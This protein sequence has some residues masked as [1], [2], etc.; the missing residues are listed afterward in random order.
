MPFLFLWMCILLVTL[1]AV[2][3]MSQNDGHAKDRDEGESEPLG[4]ALGHTNQQTTQRSRNLETT[5][6]DQ[7]TKDRY[8]AQPPGFRKHPSYFSESYIPRGRDLSALDRQQLADEWGS[9]TL[10]DSKR[11]SRP[12][13][14]FYRSFGPHRDVPN[15]EFPA[16]AWQKDTEYLGQFLSEGIA[17]TKRAME[18]ILTEY[19]KEPADRH[20]ADADFAQR[21][22]GL[23]VKKSDH[24]QDINKATSQAGGWMPVKAWNGLKKRLLHSIMTEDSFNLVMGGHSAAAG[25]LYT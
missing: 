10:V 2:A 25:E 21:S 22:A 19:G 8:Y 1:N 12:G 17:L 24:P 5:T 14:D 20:N 4:A 11:A 16:T 15:H 9:W 3:S 13:D 7:K 23:R 18:A 6:V